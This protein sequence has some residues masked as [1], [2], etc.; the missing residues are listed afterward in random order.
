[1]VAL[2]VCQHWSK[3]LLKQQAKWWLRH[4]GIDIVGKPLLKKQ[5]S[6]GCSQQ[7]HKTTGKLLSFQQQAEWRSRHK[8]ADIAGKLTLRAASPAVLAD[9]GARHR[10]QAI[11]VQNKSSGLGQQGRKTLRLSYERLTSSPSGC[12]QQGHKTSRA[13]VA[14]VQKGVNGTAAQQS[15]QQSQSKPATVMAKKHK[16]MGELLF[17]VQQAK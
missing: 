10:G 14:V 7:G 12:S 5:A 16:T 13:R 9:K 4:E 1:V 11:P 8:D 17:I 15:K 3:L 6:S 2:Q